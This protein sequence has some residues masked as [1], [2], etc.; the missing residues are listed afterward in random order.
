MFPLITKLQSEKKKHWKKERGDGQS[1]RMKSGYT[2]LKAIPSL[3]IIQLPLLPAI[4]T[5]PPFLSFISLLI[6]KPY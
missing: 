4:F 5:T 3:S 1:G 2:C 6:K